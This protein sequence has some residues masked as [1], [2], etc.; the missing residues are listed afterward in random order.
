MTL[1]Q[2]YLATYSLDLASIMTLKVHLPRLFLLELYLED[3]HRSQKDLRHASLN[4]SE[5]S[6]NHTII[7]LL[8]DT[9]KILIQ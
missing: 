3:L 2:E 5:P 1:N 7:H 8:L 6:F 4:P 9:P